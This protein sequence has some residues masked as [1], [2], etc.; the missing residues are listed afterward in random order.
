MTITDPTT[1]SEPNELSGTAITP[2]VLPVRIP[3]DRYTDP[4]FAERE[5]ADLWPHVWQVA[6]TT[7]QVPEPGDVFEYRCGRLSVLIVRNAGGELRG[8]QN[9][10]RHRGNTL[11][12]GSATGA[13]ELR[14][15]FHRWSWDLD[16][17]LVEVPSRKGFGA[18]LR[19][20]EFGLFPA[21]VDT[22]G[23]LVFVNPD[24]EAPSLADY[25]EGIPA[26]AAWAKVDEFRAN[27]MVTMPVNANW[28]VVTEGF[29]ETYHVQGIHPEM[30]A[31]IDDVH[32]SQRLW[33]RHGASYQAYG[34]PSP[35]LRDVSDQEVWESYIVTQ[36]ARMGVVEPCPVPALAPGETVADAVAAQ[37]AAHAAQRGVDLSGYTVQQRTGLSQYNLFPNTTVLIGADMLSCLVGRPGTTPDEATFTIISCYREPVG[38]PV[39]RS[40]EIPVPAG[41]PMGLVMGQDVELLRTAQRGLHQPGLT[42]LVVG[43]EECRIINF[44]RAL[45]DWLGIHPSQLV[46]L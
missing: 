17:R 35:R 9:T 37:I 25:L 19:T 38:A 36:G 41:T 45:E 10:C 22:W 16:G 44:H 40:P 28:K 18:G 12:E 33:G 8:F 15:P 6:C 21:Q 4:A 27:T 11:C 30:L 42:H 3:V 24:P 29:S 7:S 39:V 32:A 31:S 5:V 26:D 13:T 1:T 23:P 46:P 20:E 34:V 2:G 43:A 14:C